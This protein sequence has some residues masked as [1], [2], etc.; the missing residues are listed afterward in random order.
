V[1]FGG[2]SII[3]G[4]SI[5]NIPQKAVI[6][7]LRKNKTARHVI[8]ERNIS[9]EWIDQVISDPDLVTKDHEDPELE[10]HL[11]TIEEFGNRVLRVV[12][13]TTVEP[14][15]IVTAYFDR[16]MKGEL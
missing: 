3:L 10:H 14:S 16:S 11:G 8:S 15:R 5:T 1:I 13:N 4:K 7:G 2:V 9:D 6:G 12:L